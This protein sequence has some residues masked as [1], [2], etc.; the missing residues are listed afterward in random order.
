FDKGSYVYLYQ[1]ASKGRGRLEIANNPGKPEQDAFTGFLDSVH[2]RYS[3]K[4]PTLCTVTVDG[5]ELG[6]GTTSPPPSQQDNHHWR[7][8]SLDPRDEGKFLFRLHTL[9]IYFWTAEDAKLFMDSATKILHQEQ[10]EILDVPQ[11]PP[12]H[13]EVM[14]PVVQQLENIAIGD[15]AYG[16]GQTRNSR[17]ASVPLTPGLP[18]S[19]ASGDTRGEVSKNEEQPANYAPLAYNPAA[20]PAP[21]HIKH[22][23]K[24]PPPPEAESGTGLTAAA[25]ADHGFAPPPGQYQT[26]MSSP[27][28][29]HFQQQQS[30]SGP[31]QRHPSSLYSSPPPS[32]G[33]PYSPSP[34]QQGQ[35]TSS[36]SSFPPPPPTA[37]STA[38]PHG[39][40][41]PPSFAAPP[42]DPNA[43]LYNQ[44]SQPMNSP[45]T[46]ILG[47]SYIA[48]PPQPLQHLQPQYADYLQS[49][50]Q[51]QQ[52]SGGYSNY[53]SN[54]P[55]QHHHRYHSRGDEYDVHGQAYRPTE[56][57]GR[58]HSH[59]RPS[60]A[61]PG[62]QPGRL[63]Q[64]A[65]KLEKGVNKWLKKLD[66]KIG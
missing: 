27:L 45:T 41:Q 56:D 5:K 60:V 35:R 10:L 4:H 22:R 65:D 3:H 53:E 54:Q 1:D 55:H 11:A 66:K 59:H 18:A 52:P 30:F 51:N 23:E 46:Q 17:T 62:Q 21:E 39:R 43:H 16:N 13:E 24:T 8:P 36:I 2:L 37:S 7:L 63:E 61:G 12:A 6:Q 47:S 14:S 31:P 34:N 38:S 20:P 44:A 57:E 40:Q 15:P 19:G 26:P 32:A 50:P 42:K 28:P 29:G 64:R 9:D 49:R 48:P 33:L 25:Y 58:S